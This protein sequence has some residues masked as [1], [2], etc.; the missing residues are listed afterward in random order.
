[1]G[2][3]GVDTENFLRWYDDRDTIAQRAKGMISRHY[4]NAKPRTPLFVQELKDGV[5]TYVTTAGFFLDPPPP[6]TYSEQPEYGSFH[7]DPGANRDEVPPKSRESFSDRASNEDAQEERSTGPPPQPTG[8]LP[9][10]HQP[11]ADAPK[12]KPDFLKSLFAGGWGEW[13]EVTSDGPAVGIRNGKISFNGIALTK[14][15]WQALFSASPALN[16][17]PSIV[18]FL[19]ARGIPSDLA[20]RK[21]MAAGLGLDP[22]IIGTSAGNTLHLNLLKSLGR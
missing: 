7:E 3:N 12:P 21:T 18:N 1:M 17:D 19:N 13:A 9:P 5:A 20:S 15:A 10:S 14:V 8:S 2:S 11:G 22:S 4:E 6:P 16:H